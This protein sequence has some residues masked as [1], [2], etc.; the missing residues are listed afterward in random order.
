MC[1]PTTLGLEARGGGVVRRSN[2]NKET[3]LELEVCT[4]KN[5]VRKKES[6]YTEGLML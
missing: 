6:D 3:R 1:S 5:T 2:G 4:R